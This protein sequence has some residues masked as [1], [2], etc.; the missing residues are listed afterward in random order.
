MGPW[1]RSALSA[2]SCGNARTTIRARTRCIL[3]RRWCRRLP[4]L[5][6]S[7]RSRR[8]RRTPTIAARRY[9]PTSA[10]VSATSTSTPRR[11]SRRPPIPSS[12][13]RGSS[14]LRIHHPTCHRRSTRCTTIRLV[15]LVYILYFVPALFSR[16][17]QFPF[18]MRETQRQIGFRWKINNEWIKTMSKVSRISIFFLRII[19][20]INIFWSKL[21]PLT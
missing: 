21:M 15:H 18:P 10:T 8:R 4:R 17:S 11:P 14:R 5:G 12:R 13:S 2:A 6:R 1:S 9:R 20:M 16:G 3:R 7:R 19:E